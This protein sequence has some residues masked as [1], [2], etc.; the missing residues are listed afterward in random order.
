MTE[1][2]STRG[3]AEGQGGKTVWQLVATD[4][5]EMLGVSMKAGADMSK[6]ISAREVN[7]DPTLPL[8]TEAQLAF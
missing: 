2:T 6:S 1:T 5:N 7:L 4:L 8:M 3:K